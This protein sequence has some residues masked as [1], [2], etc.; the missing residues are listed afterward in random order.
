MIQ[1][2]EEAEVDTKLVSAFEERG[3]QQSILTNVESSINDTSVSN[4]LST[5][6]KNIIFIFYTKNN[7][8]IKRNKKSIF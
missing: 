7:L 2:D 5:T 3:L 6:N 8:F 4:S 1:Q